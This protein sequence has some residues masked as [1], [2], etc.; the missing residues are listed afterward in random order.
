MISSDK[1]SFT[2]SVA[3]FSTD[4]FSYLAYSHTAVF[5]KVRAHQN[6]RFWFGE[7]VLNARAAIGGDG[8][9]IG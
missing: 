1:G 4:C 7:E 8:V 3:R 6:R 9:K 2:F 5:R